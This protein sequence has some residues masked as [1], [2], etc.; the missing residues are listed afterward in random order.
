M[1]KVLCSETNPNISNAATWLRTRWLAIGG[2]SLDIRG[3]SKPCAQFKK[4]VPSSSGARTNCRRATAT[5]HSAN[6]LAGAGGSALSTY[7]SKLEGVHKYP[8]FSRTCYQHLSKLSRTL[9]CAV[10]TTS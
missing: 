3:F 7:D 2:A 4:G 1:E 10:R 5:T 9:L 8:D 6:S